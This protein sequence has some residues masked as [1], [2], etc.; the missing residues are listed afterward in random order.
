M[1]V[2][3]FFDGL[4]TELISILIGLC[5]AGGGCF[6]YYKNG[7]VSQK[8]KAGKN[9]KQRQDVKSPDKKNMSQRQEAGDDSEQTQIG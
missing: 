7:K 6:W 3:T 2:N 8:Q 1:D 4:G 5:V 9:A